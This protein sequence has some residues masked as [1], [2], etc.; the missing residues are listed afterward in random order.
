[1][2]FIPIVLTG[3]KP[4]QYV[5]EVCKSVSMISAYFWLFFF[6]THC[7]VLLPVNELAVYTFHGLINYCLHSVN[8]S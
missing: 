4:L 3:L 2:T 8:L 5:E 6:L 7:G 1:M